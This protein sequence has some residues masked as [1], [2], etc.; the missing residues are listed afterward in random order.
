M[1][2]AH[3]NFYKVFVPGYKDKRYNNLQPYINLAKALDRITYESLYFIDYNRMNLR[4]ISDNPLF[5]CG[6][7]VEKVHQEGYNFY[8]QHVPKEDLVFLSQVN[9]ISSIFL[10]RLLSV[11]DTK[12]WLQ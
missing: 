8:Y 12:S 9:R 3:F 5:F 10:R 6:E 4:Y 11:V 7:Q 1:I 2:I